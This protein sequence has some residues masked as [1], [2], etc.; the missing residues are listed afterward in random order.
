[1]YEYSVLSSYVRVQR[2]F[3]L[4]TSTAYFPV[5]HK[6]SVLSRY[7][8][9][10]CT[11]LSRY[12]R[13][14]CPFQLCTSTSYFLDMYEHSVLYFPDMYEYS[15]LFRYVRVQCTFQLCTST[16]Y[17]PVMY[18]YSVLYFPDMYE[19]T[20]NSVLSRYVWVQL[21]S[22]YVRVH[23]VQCTF[24][25]CT[26]TVFNKNAVIAMLGTDKPIYF[27]ANRNPLASMLQ[28]LIW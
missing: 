28:A 9:V 7:V 21:T 26:S 23:S 20:Q 19:Y 10:Q 18:E 6:C 22:R 15:V 11:V 14:Q 24:Q 1:M 2:T 27:V 3:Q 13:V 17:F 12:A 4:C 25:L 16:V 5:M 8:W